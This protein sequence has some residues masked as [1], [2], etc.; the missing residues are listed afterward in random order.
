MYVNLVVLDN[1]HPLLLKHTKDILAA[2]LAVIF[3]KSIK[4]AQLLVVHNFCFQKGKKKFCCKLQANQW[5]ITSS[6]VKVIERIVY[7]AIVKHLENNSILRHSQYGFQTGRSV[8]CS[9]TIL[10]QI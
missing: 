8:N 9:L 7:D 1:I 2:P 5:P 3:Q 4:A 6:A 10:L